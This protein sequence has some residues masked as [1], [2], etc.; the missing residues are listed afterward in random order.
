MTDNKLWFLG[1]NLSADEIALGAL[2]VAVVGL[3]V[4]L[5]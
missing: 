3:G 1:T 5:L 4:E 2:L